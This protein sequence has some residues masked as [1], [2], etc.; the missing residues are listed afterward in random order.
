M[1]KIK[2]ITIALTLALSTL[3]ITASAEEKIT[4]NIAPVTEISNEALNE[5]ATAE[6]ATAESYFSLLYDSLAERADD[7]FA[8]LAFLGTL[9]F[10]VAYK[11]GLIPELARTRSGIT[12]GIERSSE[13]SAE[14]SAAITEK[15][16]SL[17]DAVRAADKS[18]ADTAS[19][20]TALKE[21]LENLSTDAEL[22]R[23]TKLI[24][25]SQVD[26]LYD[27]FMSSAIPQYQKDAAAA[28][29][30]SMREELGAYD[31]GEE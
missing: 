10:G 30:H 2:I 19:S 31:L 7:I 22:Q 17:E 8:L 20:L 3:A 23:K 24:I 13:K 26:L 9:F 18:Q 5:D 4:E 16:A 25:A 14:Q 15:L 11:R 12:E 27:I 1:K 29:I 28:R 21:S 6:P